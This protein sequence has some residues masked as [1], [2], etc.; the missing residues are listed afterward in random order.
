MGR[1][2]RDKG[3]PENVLFSRLPFNPHLPD[4][5]TC[6]YVIRDSARPSI[7][8]EFSSITLSGA[9]A[10]CSVDSDRLLLWTEET[11]VGLQNSVIWHWK[12]WWAC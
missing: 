11:M 1:L 9:L 3:L 5:H 12:P 6:M 4:S 2:S 8:H 10:I 7:K